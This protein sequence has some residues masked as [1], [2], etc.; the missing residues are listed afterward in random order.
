[1]KLTDMWNIL[2]VMNQRILLFV[3]A[4]FIGGGTVA[5]HAPASLFADDAGIKVPVNNSLQV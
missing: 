1:M 3:F 5:Q 4:L 2:N